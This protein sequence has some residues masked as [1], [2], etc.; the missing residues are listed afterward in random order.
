MPV[1]V[2]LV[3]WVIMPKIFAEQQILSITSY[4]RVWTICYHRPIKNFPFDG[5]IKNDAAIRRFRFE[6]VRLKTLEMCEL[7]AIRNC[8]RMLFVQ[9]RIAVFAG[10]TDIPFCTISMVSDP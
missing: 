3:C 8:L 6:L 7:G 4:N 1:I 9:L 2:Q 10:N 5:I